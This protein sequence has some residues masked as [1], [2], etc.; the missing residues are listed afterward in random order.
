MIITRN[1]ILNA[2]IGRSGFFPTCRINGRGDK[3]F[4][5]L[6]NSKGDLFYIFE[7]YLK[8]E[9]QKELKT[10]YKI[11]E[12]LLNNPQIKLTSEKRTNKSEKRVIEV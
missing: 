3:L 4:I 1:T 12:Y 8:G 5:N 6:F 10:Y 9:I 11:Y 2:I 7:A